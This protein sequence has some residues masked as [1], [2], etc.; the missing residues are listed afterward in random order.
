MFDECVSLKTIYCSDSDTE[1][2]FDPECET[3]DMFGV[4]RELKG[5]YGD[6]VVAYADDK[7]GPEYAKSAKLGGYFT[8]KSD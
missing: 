7:T 8:P 4:C 5:V 6:T 1:W 2:I 3:E